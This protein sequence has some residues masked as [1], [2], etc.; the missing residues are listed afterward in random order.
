MTR[1]STPPGRSTCDDRGQGADRI[2]KVL[3]HVDHEHGVKGAGGKA[4][5]LQVA[6]EHVK[7]EVPGPSHPPVGQLDAL[8]AP[9]AAAG[10]VEQQPDP[11]ADVEDQGRAIIAEMGAGR[12]QKLPAGH[13]AGSLLGDVR[14]VDHLGVRGL[15][16]ALHHPSLEN[17]TTWAAMQLRLLARVV[18]GRG[19]LLAG[20]RGGRALEGQRQLGGATDPTGA[21]GHLSLLSL[22]AE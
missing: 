2:G 4:G 7:A 21:G 15:Q 19:D 1:H 9:A 10:L 17:P 11:T 5:L 16:L 20:W 3:Q 6:L 13:A 22:H 8:R 12:R 18:A 14:L